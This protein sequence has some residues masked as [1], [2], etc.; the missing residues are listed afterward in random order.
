QLQVF[1]EMVNCPRPVGGE[2]LLVDQAE[3][4]VR[5]RAAGVRCQRLFKG[6]DGTQVI[7]GGHAV[8]AREVIRVFFLNPA[9]FTDGAASSPARAEQNQ[10]SPAPGRVRKRHAANLSEL[11]VQR[12]DGLK[13]AN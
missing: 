13:R 1:F 10:G 4:E 9:A 2:I 3:F 5:R 7:Q 12:N 6:V 11:A 8:F